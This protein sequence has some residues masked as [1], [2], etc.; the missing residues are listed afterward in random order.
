MTNKDA[1]ELM[2]TAV[3]LSRHSTCGAYRIATCTAALNRLA[4]EAK[5]NA[6]RLCSDERYSQDLFDKKVDSISRRAFHELAEIG[7]SLGGLKVEV[8]GDPR[9]SCLQIVITPNTPPIRF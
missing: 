2:E 9:G 5:T 1:I 8:H 4:R 6:E 3:M 7:I